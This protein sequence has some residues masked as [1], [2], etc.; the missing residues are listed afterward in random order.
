MCSAFGTSLVKFKLAR[1]L[2]RLLR[3]DRPASPSQTVT[4]TSLKFRVSVQVQD[5]C[6]VL[7]VFAVVKAVVQEQ[8]HPL[9]KRVIVQLVLLRRYTRNLIRPKFFKEL[10]MIGYAERDRLLIG[11][12]RDLEM[13]GAGSVDGVHP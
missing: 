8:P 9:E 11:H 7:V 12:T 5:A 13:L 2:N 1:Y 4:N 10:P 3:P 6:L